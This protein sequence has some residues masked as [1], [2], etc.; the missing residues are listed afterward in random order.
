MFGKLKEKLAGGATRLNGKMD[1][2]EAIC[3][4]CVLV[5]AADGDFSDDEASVA[6]ERLLNH[7]TISAAFSAT[8]IETLS[9]IHI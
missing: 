6:L 2:L 3:A 8:Q 5:G 7:E 1:L 9:L 4:A